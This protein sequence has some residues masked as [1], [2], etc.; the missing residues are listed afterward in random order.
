MPAIALVLGLISLGMLCR[1]LFAPAVHAL[2]FFVCVR[3][4]FAML[5]TGRD[6]GT[7]VLAGIVAA[8]LTAATGRLLFAFAPSPTLRFIVAAGFLVPAAIAGYHVVFGWLGSPFRLP[9]DGRW[10]H[11]SVRSRLALWLG[12]NVPAWILPAPPRSTLSHG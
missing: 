5:H 10:P 9:L 11:V 1:A 2:P 6:V 12:G 8:A 4:A 3:I 7:A